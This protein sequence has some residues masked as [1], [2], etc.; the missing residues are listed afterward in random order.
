MTKNYDKSVDVW[1]FGIV[2]YFLLSG[3]FPFIGDDELSL[4]H[5]IMN[6]EVEFT[7]DIWHHR[8]ESA[9]DLIRQF[10]TKDPEQRITIQNALEHPWFVEAHEVPSVSNEVRHEVMGRM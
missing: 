3:E 6:R 8:S 4:L 10:L 5:N 2:L 9:Q 1:S 7:A